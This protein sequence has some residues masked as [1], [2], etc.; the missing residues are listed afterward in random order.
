MALSQGKPVTLA[1]VGNPPTLEV[2]KNQPNW[3]WW[4]IWAGMVRNTT[5]AQYKEM[6]ESPRLL[7]QEDQAWYDIANPYRKTC[8]LPELPLKEKYPVNFSGTWILDEAKSEF[9]QRGSANAP[10]KMEVAHDD[11]QLLIKKYTV[12][13]WGDDRIS[14]EEVMLD[15][16]EMKSVFFN[17][18]RITTATLDPETKSINIVSLTKMTRG[19]NSMQR[20]STEIWTLEEGGKFLKIRQTSP[21]F[22]GGETIAEW[23]Y[24]RK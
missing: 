3:C 13:E 14:A 16:S 7:T 23:A 18:P 8:D 2:L 19:G 1:E 24:E 22:R 10:Y 12:V 6:L 20:K 21:G 15:G 9:G 4:V 5:K 11:D 17:A